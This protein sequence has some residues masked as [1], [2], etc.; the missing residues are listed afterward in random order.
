MSTQT[1]EE[2]DPATAE[3][4]RIRDEKLRERERP[5]SHA[6]GG[7]AESADVES[8]L[9]GKLENVRRIAAERAL[10]G[11]PPTPDEW[12]RRQRATKV[13]QLRERW[14]APARQLAVE[15]VDASGEWGKAFEKIKARLGTGFL[16]GLIGK[17]G[18]G[19]TLLATQLMKA[20]TENLRSARFASAIEFFSEVKASYRKDAKE[21][22][23]DVVDNFR[24]PSLLVLDE[25]G[26]RGETQWEDNLLFELLNRRYEDLKDTV[27]IC[28]FSKEEFTA[29]IGESVA[30]RMRETGGIIDC[31]NWPSK[32]DKEAAQ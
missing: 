9:A 1:I 13:E 12:E 11:P 8:I 3:C 5:I 20:N 23:L 2:M 26:R 28:N 22:E 7:K 10:C 4:L 29:A 6:A 32:R 19:K 31:A 25:V 21:S 16:V 30:S 17:R 24:R 15:T 27:L 14:N 18:T